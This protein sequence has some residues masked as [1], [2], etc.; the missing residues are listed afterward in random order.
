MYSNYGHNFLNT[1]LR[2]FEERDSLSIV[3]DQIGSPTTTTALAEMLWMVVARAEISG[4]YH[5]SC[6]GAVSWFEFAKAIEG[7]RNFDGSL[8]TRASINPVTSQQYP[9]LA[10]RPKYSVLNSARVTSLLEL[11]ERD[12][13]VCLVEVFSL[14]D[15]S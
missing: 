12:W 2:L 14:G 1:M 9:S 11:G 7:L 5:W 8:S 13:S 6:D 4:L 3:D 15:S 10:S